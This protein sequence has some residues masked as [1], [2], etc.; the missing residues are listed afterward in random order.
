MKII[1]LLISFFLFFIEMDAQKTIPLYNGVIPGS[2]ATTIK[3]KTEIE[4]NGVV[5]ISKIVAPSLSVYL[6]PKEKRTG[7]SVIICPGGGYSVVAVKHEGTDVAK[8]MAEWG[9]AAFVLKYR[10][11]DDSLMLNKETGPLQDVQEAMKYV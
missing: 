5:I 6:P 7:A 9:V 1:F 10:L 3:E 4:K 8:K 2:K 11:P